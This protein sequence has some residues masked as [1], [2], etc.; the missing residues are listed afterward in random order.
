MCITWDNYQQSR[1][2]C[3]ASFIIRDHFSNC[4]YAELHPADELPAIHEFLF[5]AWRKKDGYEFWGDP[6]YLV[7]PKKTQLEFPTLE[8]FFASTDNVK[9]YIRQAVL[10]QLW[11]PQEFGKTISGIFLIFTKIARQYQL[12]NLH[13][14][15]K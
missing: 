9:L 6:Q 7:I 11:L 13:R 1:K 8:K 2:K 15:Y 10:K 3:L 12:F 4:F 5:N 14:S